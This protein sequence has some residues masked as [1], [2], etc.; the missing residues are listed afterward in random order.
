M[1]Q[2]N[3][4]FVLALPDGWEDRTVHCFIGPEDVGEQP[5]L[6]VNID[7]KPESTA[8]AEYASLRRDSA[9]AALPAAEVASEG[10]ET[11]PSGT[12]CYSLV[13]RWA[14]PDGRSLIRRHFYL[15]IDGTGY[16][17]WV[18]LSKRGN[19]MLSAQI[20]GMVDTIAGV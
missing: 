16:T 7:R 11:L 12:K 6:L 1:G 20:A 4:Q 9:L 15:M 14:H 17:C 19:K 8:L 13:C 5:A 2:T 18:D 10:E 3:N